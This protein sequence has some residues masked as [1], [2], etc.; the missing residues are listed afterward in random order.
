MSVEHSGAPD[1]PVAWVRADDSSADRPKSSSSSAR[2]DLPD[3]VYYDKIN[4]YLKKHNIPNYGLAKVL[5]DEDLGNS[6]SVH[7]TISATAKDSKKGPQNERSH[8]RIV[9]DTVGESLDKFTSMKQLAICWRICPVFSIEISPVDSSKLTWKDHQGTPLQGI[10]LQGTPFSADER[11]NLRELENKLKERMGTVEFMA[12]ELI[13]A[14]PKTGVT[15]Q[16][17]H[18]LESFYWLL[19]WIVLCHTHR[20]RKAG[21]PYSI[22]SQAVRVNYFLTQ[23]S[24]VREK[25]ETGEGGRTQRSEW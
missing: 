16:A 23:T 4:A 24:E 21:D 17:H 8:M 13:D 14:D 11:K 12:I 7:V 3:V 1:V 20:D 6:C 2:N 19:V 10:S 15:H 5:Y 25:R 22:P 18:N 9:L